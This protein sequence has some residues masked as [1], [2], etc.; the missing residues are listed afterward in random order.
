M[1]Q[2][3]IRNSVLYSVEKVFSLLT[4]PF[5]EAQDLK[6]YSQRGFYLLGLVIVAITLILWW[7]GILTTPL[8]QSNVIIKSI[9]SA[10]IEKTVVLSRL[11]DSYVTLAFLPFIAYFAL[12]FWPKGRRRLGELTANIFFWILN[13]VIGFG[14]LC[15]E[16][17]W[18]SFFFVILLV[19]GIAALTTIEVERLIAE[20]RVRSEFE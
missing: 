7:Q 10:V 2:Q 5:A 14:E 19:A 3:R 11:P 9:Y 13:R 8:S 17:R 20:R 15:I 16:H 6:A 4:R 18:F 12:F 1:W